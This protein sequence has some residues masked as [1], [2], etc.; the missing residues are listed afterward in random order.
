M[1][2]YNRSNKHKVSLTNITEEKWFINKTENKCCVS[3]I[4]IM[5]EYILQAVLLIQ[6]TAQVTLNNKS[7]S[8]KFVSFIF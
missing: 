7:F 5:D 1:V 3:N 2:L 4:T 8:N 6:K